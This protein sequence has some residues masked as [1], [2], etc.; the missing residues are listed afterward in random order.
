M[1]RYIIRRLVIF[2]PTL[3]A[4]AILVFLMIDLVPGDP[5]VLILGVETD[6]AAISA[7]RKELG[8]DRPLY[9]RMAL[10]FGKAFTGDLGDSLFLHQPMTEALADRYPVT[11]SLAI[12]AAVVAMGAGIPAG[13]I[14]ATHQGRVADWLAMVLALIVL[15]IPSFWL[16]LNLIFFLGVKLRWFPIGGYVSPAKDFGDYLKHLVLPGVSLGLAY[17][18]SIA[19]ITRTSML[20]VLRM[21]YVRTAQAKGLRNMVVIGRHAFRNALIPV[22]TVVGLS[23]GGL[24]GG[25]AVTE[26]VYTLPGVGRLVVEAVQRRDYPVIQGGILALTVTYLVINLLVDLLYAWTDPRIRYE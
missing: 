18:A 2:V 11:I 7:M 8:L 23:F 21:D 19:R 5:V 16:A 13:I 14:A 1:G 15:S 6:G 12:F 26:T 17:A 9:E 25:S 20:E 22:L 10:W 24:L 4:V 3:F